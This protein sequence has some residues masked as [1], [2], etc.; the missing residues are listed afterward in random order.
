MRLLFADFETAG[1]EPRP[2]YPPKPVGI[3]LRPVGGYGAWKAPRYFAFGHPCENNS[4][5]AEAQKVYRGYLRDGFVPVFHNAAFD[6]A[7]AEEWWGVAR[8]AEFHDTLFLAFLYNPHA[9]TFSLKPLAEAD[10]GEPPTER[11]ELRDW[12]VE[13]VPEAKKKKSTWGAYISLAPGELVGRY[14]NGDV[15]RTQRLFE[16]YWRDLM[17]NQ[18]ADIARKHFE[19]Y[20]RERELVPVLAGMEA[21]GIPIR[22]KFL[23]KQ[24][25]QHQRTLNRVETGILNRLK[26]AKTKREGFKFTGECLADA[27]ERAKKVKEWIVTKEGYR[28]TNVE[29]LREVC[30]D[31]KLVDELEVRYQLAT[32]I[33]TF[34]TPWLAS[35]R[36]NDGKFYARFNQV[37]QSRDGTGPQVGAV[38]GRLSMSPNLQNVIRSDKDPRVPKLR[39]YI[40]SGSRERVLVQRDYSQQELRITGHYEGGPLLR[41]YLD[42]PKIDAHDAVRALIRDLIGVDLERRDVKDL[43]FGLLYGMGAPKLAR[44]LGIPVDEARRL[45]RAHLNALPGIKKLRQTLEDNARMNVPLYTWGGRRYFCEKPKIRDGRLWSFEYKQLNVLIQGSAADATKQA[46]INYSKRRWATECPLLLQVHDELLL[47]APTHL[48]RTI[49]KELR[50]AMLD[51]EFKVPL[52]SDGKTGRVSWHQMQ[53]VD[54]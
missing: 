10:L 24:L 14:A 9:P 6:L 8:P 26:V 11:D 27:L 50:Q 1:I 42:N 36:E 34:M 3:S 43:N 38:T 49:H 30:A 47:T 4:T 29:D 37:R 39:D 53:K 20:N 46:M 40:W 44:K 41:M 35:A 28:A 25:P 17:G 48:H 12:I 45:M 18:P 32:C 5:E 21:H 13:H 54:Y 23:E 51:V 15:S 31:T 52:L 7:V 2:Q 19:A 16:K 22:T 33:N